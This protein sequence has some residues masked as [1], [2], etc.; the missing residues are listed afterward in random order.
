MRRR[1]V[2][3]R[4]RRLIP[5]QLLVPLLVVAGG[6]IAEGRL[7]TPPLVWWAAVAGC[8]YATADAVLDEGGGLLAFLGVVIGTAAAML[9]GGAA[10]GLGLAGFASLV[11]LRHR[12]RRGI[13]EKLG[14]A[15]LSG[16]PLFYGALAAGRPADGVLPWALA[17]WVQLVHE[18]ISDVEAEPGARG[19]GRRSRREVATAVLALAFVPVSLV[20]PARA[21]Y[22]LG[23]FLVAMFA[24]L[25]LLAVG[26]RLL[27]GRVERLGVL[28]HG[29]MALGLIA[30]VIGKVG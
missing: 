17:G 30:L 1:C 4:R 24:E 27:V 29:A 19:R 18:L 12:G 8:C 5:I 26:T 16:L 7:A 28:V 3:E 20:W 25:A 13:I 15:A 6:W 21:G 11:T 22:G 23:Y 9:V 14:G 10:V 2:A